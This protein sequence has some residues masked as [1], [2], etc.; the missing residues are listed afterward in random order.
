MFEELIHKPNLTVKDLNDFLGKTPF[1]TY[2]YLMDKIKWKDY[3]KKWIQQDQPGLI[4][5]Y[6]IV[7]KES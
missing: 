1:K 4:H 7:F 5:Y 2:P 6:F 3:L